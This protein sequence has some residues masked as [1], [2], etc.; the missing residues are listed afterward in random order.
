MTLLDVLI[1]GP[2]W[3][4]V[5]G[6]AARGMLDIVE[7][8]ECVWLKRSAILLAFLFGTFA[9]WFVGNNYLGQ[10]AAGYKDYPELAS[11]AINP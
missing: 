3:A 6:A 2:F 9:T 1:C 11:G 10:A 7:P 4:F 8:S 5:T